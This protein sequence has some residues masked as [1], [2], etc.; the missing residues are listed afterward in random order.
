MSSLGYH[1]CIRLADGSA[2]ARDAP[3]R[4]TLAEVVLDK[5]VKTDLHCFALPDTHLH[6]SALCD[7]VQPGE[8]CRRVGISLKRQLRTQAGFQMYPP[9]P[10]QD[11]RHLEQ[12]TRYILTQHQRHQVHADPFREATNLPDLLGLRAIGGE[13][14]LANLRRLLPRLSREH[15]LE[16][17]GAPG[18]RPDLAP[19]APEGLW[20]SLAEAACRAACLPDLSGSGARAV[21]ARRAVLEIAGGRLPKCKLGELL[22]IAPRTVHWLGRQAPDPALVRA[23]ML[24]L[25]LGARLDGALTQSRG[26]LLNGAHT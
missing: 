10:I 26:A 16:W 21:A 3:E 15:L 25:A 7:K 13:Y 8:L 18:L 4:R 11:Q 5:G 20:R 1:L 24:Q 12:L 22:G 23:T 6:M 14:T 9:I 17:L 19:L 2:I